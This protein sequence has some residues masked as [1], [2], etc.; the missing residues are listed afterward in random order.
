LLERVRRR[1]GQTAKHHGT[2]R[3]IWSHG[4]GDVSRHRV[5]RDGHV[6]VWCIDTAPGGQYYRDHLAPLDSRLMATGDDAE[7]S[8]DDDD[9]DDDDE[10]AAAAAA[11]EAS[12]IRTTPLGESRHLLLVSLISSKQW[13]SQWGGAVGGDA[14]PRPYHPPQTSVVNSCLCIKLTKLIHNTFI[15]KA[16]QCPKMRLLPG[17][18]PNPALGSFQHSPNPPLMGKVI[19]APHQKP[20][21]QLSAIGLHFRPF[22]PRSALPNSNSWLRW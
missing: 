10:L 5:G 20:Y 4:N 19:A 17:F 2:V 12:S 3:V 22:G 7:A 14:P 18:S 6:D 21:L 16:F 13:R 1:I 11:R 15:C 9:D 8:D